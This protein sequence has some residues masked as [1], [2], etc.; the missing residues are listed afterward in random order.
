MELR[1][2]R[3]ETISQLRF[4]GYNAAWYR[5][6]VTRT[7]PYRNSTVLYDPVPFVPRYNGILGG[8]VN[9]YRTVHN[10]KSTSHHM[11]GLFRTFQTLSLFAFPFARY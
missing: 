3:V 8:H 5:S 9:M 2:L 1:S 7:V 10:A 11:I 6:N 4:A